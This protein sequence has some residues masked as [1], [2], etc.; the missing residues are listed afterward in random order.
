MTVRQSIDPVLIL[1]PILL[2]IEIISDLV[3]LI[4]KGVTFLTPHQLLQLLFFAKKFLGIEKFH[5]SLIPWRSEVFDTHIGDNIQK[6]R[7]TVL[8]MKILHVRIMNRLY[9]INELHTILDQIIDLTRGFI[10]NIHIF[11]ELF[12]CLLIFC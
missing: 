4:L 6:L 9:Q 3:Q 8:L 10:T 12:E 7:L 11:N 1:G 2:N 5:I